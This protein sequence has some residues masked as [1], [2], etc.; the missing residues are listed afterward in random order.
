MTIQQGK[1]GAKLNID[2][3]CDAIVFFL[4]KAKIL[5]FLFQYRKKVVRNGSKSISKQGIG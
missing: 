5:M 1:I 3:T 4:L 2:S